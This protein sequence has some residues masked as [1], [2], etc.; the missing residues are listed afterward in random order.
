MENLF[1]RRKALCIQ[2]LFQ[3]NTEIGE[4][5]IIEKFTFEMPS[6]FYDG[7]SFTLHLYLKKIA[8]FV[9]KYYSLYFR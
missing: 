1:P 8:L 5:K 6:L 9:I 4:I 2:N 7:P 3:T